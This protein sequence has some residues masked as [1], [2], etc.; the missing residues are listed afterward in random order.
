VIPSYD[1]DAV[2]GTGAVT[3]RKI[4]RSVYGEAASSTSVPARAARD[5]VRFCNVKDRRVWRNR[6]RVSRSGVKNAVSVSVDQPTDPHSVK[7]G[8]IH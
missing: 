3:G 1:D 2:E 5:G 7:G 4:D 6:N 8:E